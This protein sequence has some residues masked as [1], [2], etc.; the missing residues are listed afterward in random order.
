MILMT[1]LDCHFLACRS[2]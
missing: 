1:F 2:K